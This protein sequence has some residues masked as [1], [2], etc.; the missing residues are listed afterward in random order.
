VLDKK[1]ED[2][3]AGRKSLKLFRINKILSDEEM[4]NIFFYI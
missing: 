2:L 1:A 3:V 4:I